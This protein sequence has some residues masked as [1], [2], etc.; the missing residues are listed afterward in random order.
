MAQ[1]QFM[2]PHVLQKKNQQTKHKVIQ[3]GINLVKLLNPLGLISENVSNTLH[4][5]PSTTSRSYKNQL[6]VFSV[7]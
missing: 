4:A 3:R 5:F 7:T 1:T 6:L 2:F